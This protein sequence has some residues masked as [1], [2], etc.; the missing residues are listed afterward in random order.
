MRFPNA[1]ASEQ[2]RR[3]FYAVTPWESSYAK[4]EDVPDYLNEASLLISI[5]KALGPQFVPACING[6]QRIKLRKDFIRTVKF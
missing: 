3:I 5:V 4:I 2:I 6:P 1:S